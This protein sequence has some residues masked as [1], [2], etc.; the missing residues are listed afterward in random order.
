MTR[1]LARPGSRAARMVPRGATPAIAALLGLAVALLVALWLWPWR[2]Y[3]FDPTDEGVQLVQVDRVL[4]GERPQ[5][6]FET[7]YT[8]GYFGFHAGLLRATGGGLVATRTFGVLLQAATVGLGASLAAAWGGIASAVVTALLATGFLLPFSMRS[9]APFNVPYPGWLAMPCALVAQAAAARL[10]MLRAGEARLPRDAVLEALPWALLAG[11]SSGAAFSIKPNAG[12]L[13]LAGAA[14]A[15]TAGW[16][17]R[18]VA[19]AVLSWLVRGAALAATWLLL[20]S[21]LEVFTA[22]A[23]GLPVLLAVLRPPPPGVHDDE[24]ESSSRLVAPL[25]A[26]LFALATGFLLP[27]LPWASRL[28]A[29]VGLAEAIGRVLHLDGSVVRAYAVPI[30]APGPGTF[31][32]AAGIAAAALFAARDAG[33]ARLVP[34]VIVAGMVAATLAIRATGVG[35][36]VAAENAWSWA[37]PLLLAIGSLVPAS[38]LRGVRERALVA[39]A[40]LYQLQVFPRVDLIHVAMSAPPVLLAAAVVASRLAEVPLAAARRPRTLVAGTVA[41]AAVLA[42]GRALPTML[43]RLR[44]PMVP[45]DLGP[46]APLVVAQ[47]H[48]GE[49][50]GLSRTVREVRRRSRP[51]EPLFAFPDLPGIGF[52]AGRPTPW[53]WLYFVPGRPS[54]EDQGAILAELERS[55]PAV[56]VLDANPEPAFAG[57]EA[58]YDRIAEHLSRGWVAV[59]THGDATV[60]VRRSTGPAAS[61]PQASSR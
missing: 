19:G 6:D 44:E 9:G 36:R 7:S 34:W 39:F 15:A 42:G 60:L 51:G 35:P 50:D 17:G 48:A 28:V 8:P 47:R 41:L 18:G 16:Q 31:A 23:F 21:G 4:A 55:P 25:L 40:A 12:L 52:L 5:I 22:I 26:D 43:E 56:V 20:R 29:S 1:G 11:L 61:P 57:A 10:A 14:V 27:I 3:G 45:L 58:Y 49:Y 24:A 59:A 2:L 46:R 33:R 13:A 30:E 54:R 37:G 32:L 38:G 53:T